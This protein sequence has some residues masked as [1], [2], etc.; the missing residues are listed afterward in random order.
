MEAFPWFWYG[1]QLISWLAGIYIIAKNGWRKSWGLILVACL[2]FLYNWFVPV[3]DWFTGVSSFFGYQ[4][5]SDP[6]L[7]SEIGKVYSLGSLFL[8]GS[9]FGTLRFLKHKPLPDLSF[10]N[11]LFVDKSFIIIGLL[12]LTW[13]VIL[14]NI[15]ASGISLIAVFSLKNQSERDILFSAD[16]FS[17]GIDLLTNCLPTAIF[18]LALSNPKQRSILLLLLG[19]WLAFSLLAGWR[20]R[21]ILLL[22]MFLGWGVRH[23]NWSVSKL[24]IFG[25]LISISLAWLT[26]NRMAIA[27]RQF[28]LV[29]NDLRKFDFQILTQELS[30]SRTFHATLQH[31]ESNKIERGGISSWI[32]H[33]SNKLQPKTYFENGERPKPWI[34]KVTKEWIPPGWPYN[35]NPA[36]SQMEEFYLTFGWLGLFLGMSLMGICVALFDYPFQSIGIQV[37]QI[38]CI[39]LCF[40]WISRGFFLYQLQIS[41]AALLPFALV[42]LSH[43]YLRHVRPNK[44]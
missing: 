11:E 13:S 32:H 16:F 20:Y 35:P 18:L 27:K 24:L 23:Y 9:Y 19:F 29:T 1:L 5:S 14:W 17:S 22:L 31:M 8:I 39:A 43:A 25:V 21:I 36:V 2:Y 30:N 44:A 3:S 37:F 7:L 12:V 10:F 41:A 26:L 6:A 33:L 28:H 42:C 4:L 34:L 15:H 38:I 40:Q